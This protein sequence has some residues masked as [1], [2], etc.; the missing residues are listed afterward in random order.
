MSNAVPGRPIVLVVE[1]EF[2]VRLNTVLMIEDAGFDVLEAV[3]A[4]SGH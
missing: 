2:L 4:E 1:D 3:D